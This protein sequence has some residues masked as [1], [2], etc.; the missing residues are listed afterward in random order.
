MRV[1][2]C[3]CFCILGQTAPGAS[4][5]ADGPTVLVEGVQPCGVPLWS[6]GRQ[7][8]PRDPL[9]RQFPPRRANPRSSGLTNFTAHHIGSNFSFTP[10]F[11]L[12]HKPSWPLCGTRDPFPKGR[13][14]FSSSHDSPCSHASSS[15]FTTD[16][17]YLKSSVCFCS[18]LIPEQQENLFA[19]SL[20]F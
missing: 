3:L 11:T 16:T 10:P 13:C 5:G 4:F 9:L 12:K 20:A 6:K 19:Y 7:R 15:S 2:V 17:V 14:G 8:A 1:A 18:D